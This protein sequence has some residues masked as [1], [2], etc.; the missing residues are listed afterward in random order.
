MRLQNRSIFQP[1]MRGAYEIEAKTDEAVVY[2]YDEISFWGVSAESFVKDLNAISSGTIHLHVNSPGGAVFDGVSIF[3]AIKQHKSKVIAH[4][5][6]L[7]ASIASV[8]VM[9]ADEVMMSENAFLMVH[10]PWSIV[11]GNSEEMRKEADLLDKVGGT[12]MKTY[13][14]KSG[15]DESEI[16]TLMQ[17]ETWMTAQEA[18][19][20]G[21]VDS[22]EISDKDKDKDKKK[23][24]A[25][26]TVFDLSAFMNVPEQL[27]EKKPEPTVREAEKALRDVGFNKQQAKAILA[28]GFSE[29]KRDVEVPEPI[30]TVEAKRDVEPATVKKKDRVSDLLIR[31]EI[32]STINQLRRKSRMKTISQYK[33]DLEKPYEKVSRHRHKGYY[34]EP[35]PD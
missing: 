35:G 4:I 26:A 30:P 23:K 3:N 25:Q 28:E 13:T 6:G 22:I 34:R 33:E 32:V 12:I 16:K 19:D 27:K 18:L 31:A 24:K 29:N 20:F 10:E 11:A 1:N 7:A 2:L 21:F 14:D 5:D 15:K 9:A 8:I 17:A